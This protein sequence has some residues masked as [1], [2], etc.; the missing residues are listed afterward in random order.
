M[1]FLRLIPVPSVLLACLVLLPIACTSDR[2]GGGPVVVE[3]G[4]RKVTLEEVREL[5]ARSHDGQSFDAASSE[6]QRDFLET[7]G[8]KEILLRLAREAGGLEPNYAQMIRQGR[9]ARLLQS[10]ENSLV[11]KVQ[12][13]SAGLDPLLEKFRRK[14]K[15]RMMLM[16]S[17]SAS[18]EARK[19]VESGTPFAE[20][21]KKYSL[22]PKTAALGGDVGWKVPYTVD[23]DMA[24]DL[25]LKGDRQ[26]GY[27]SPIIHTMQ[28]IELAQIDSIAPVDRSQ[29][30][31]FE[32]LT[33]ITATRI[34]VRQRITSWIDS[35]KTASQIEVL[36][37]P[38][39][40][41]QTR[42]AAYY[43]SLKKNEPPL[44]RGVPRL[45]T[46]PLSAF[47][48][49]ELKTPLYKLQGKTYTLREYLEGLPDVPNSLWPSGGAPEDLVRLIET[50]ALVQVEIDLARRAGLDK[51]PKLL[52]SNRMEE[53][54]V[55]L[56]QFVAKQ[57][58][59][60]VTITEDEMRKYYEENPDR[61]RNYEKIRLA[62][63]VFPTANEAAKFYAEASA[64][65]DP[66]WWADRMTELKKRQDVLVQENGDEILYSGTIPEEMRDLC[67]KGKAAEQG[68]IVGPARYGDRGWAVGRVQYR[69]HEGMQPF[70]KLTVQL[71]TILDE[72]KTGER[73]D[74]LVKESRE[75]MGLKIYPDRVPAGSGANKG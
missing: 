59:K 18:A 8:S 26:P 16:T 58:K 5:Y 27:L 57:V 42:M 68:D 34:R 70:E 75:K 56:E 54:K 37:D 48:P 61:F 39:P 35:V 22:E 7:I 2:A 69:E 65:K 4:D 24:E 47:R 11:Q 23:T 53:E 31:D 66:F 38:L 12:R 19:L 52:A 40:M 6:E 10:L 15:L 62:H 49:E 71:R 9:D 41:V 45:R 64:K 44:P 21:A 30:P 3:L 25:W 73:V 55:L 67:E 36:R 50:R 43:D 72:Q 32:R 17:D 20:V 46:A 13:D 1:S 33:R 63:V 51:D 74:Q 29:D 60:D 14:M 28:G